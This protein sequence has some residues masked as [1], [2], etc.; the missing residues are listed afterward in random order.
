MKK[1]VVVFAVLISVV[2]N[3]QSTAEMKAHFENY[4]QT[5]KKHGDIQGVINAM[6]HLDIIEPSQARR[7]TIA[8]LYVTEGR[9]LQALNTI[10]G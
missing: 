2:M 8:Y 1:L 3:A 6:T 9:H 7:D 10:R 4:Y 5:M